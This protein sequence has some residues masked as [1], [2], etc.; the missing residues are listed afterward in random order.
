LAASQ[1]ILRQREF[2]KPLPLLEFSSLCLTWNQS[3]WHGFCTL[4]VLSGVSEILRHLQRKF[5]NAPPLG[6]VHLRG[7][8]MTAKSVGCIW[9]SYLPVR[10]SWAMNCIS[11]FPAAF[12]MKSP[13]DPENG[14]YMYKHIYIYREE[15]GLTRCLFVCQLSACPSA[16]LVA[17]TGLR[18]NK[19]SSQ[20]KWLQTLPSWR[21]LQMPPAKRLVSAGKK[22]NEMGS[23]EDI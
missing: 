10:M 20:M 1:L 5:R 16:L 23:A 19:I 13:L 21:M 22:E 15:S 12:V 4:A 9:I 14:I 7:S 18:G 8:R 17:L 11:L 3:L 2:R 6:A